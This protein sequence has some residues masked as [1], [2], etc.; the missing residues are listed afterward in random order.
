M[1]RRRPEQRLDYHHFPSEYF[2]LLTQFQATGHYSFSGL[3][4][5]ECRALQKDVYRFFG[6]LRNAPVDDD[7]AR[8][9]A[10]I[11]DTMK[12]RYLP[13]ADNPS[14]YTIEWYLNPIVRLVR[15]AQATSTPA[16]EE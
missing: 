2:T 13:L 12:C 6:F 9:W 5:R 11:A 14:L 3:T 7:Y 1:K 10:E 8:T 15:E 4:L 16:T